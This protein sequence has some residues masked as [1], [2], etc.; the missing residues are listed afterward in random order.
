MKQKEPLVSIIA[1][2]Y[3]AESYLTRCI[4]SILRQ[5]YKNF[6]LLLIDDGSTDQSGKMCDDYAKRDI[7]IRVYHRENSGVSA[8]RNFALGLCQGSYIQFLDSDDWITTDSTKLLVRSALETKCDLVIADFYRVVGERVSQKGDIEED[9]IL[10]REQFAEH[11]M[12]N[13]AD[14]YYGV[15]WNKLYRRD[16]I[17]ENQ[18][19]MDPAISWC[20]DFLFNLEYIRHADTF[21]ALQAPVY[22]YF[23]RKGSLVSQS[24]SISN[25]IK[26]KLNI[27]DYYNQ[28]YKEIYKEEDYENIRLHIYHF[29]FASAKDNMLPPSPLPGAKK[30]G[31]ERK[32]ILPAAI[33]AEGILP[34]VYRIRKLLERLCETVAAKN[35]LTLDE[36]MLLLY[37]NQPACTNSIRSLAE[38]SGYSRRRISS[39]LQRLS[40]KELIKVTT[41]KRK[42]TCIQTLPAAKAILSD[43]E[44]AQNDFDIIRFRSL[45]EQ[46][47]IAYGKISHQIKENIEEALL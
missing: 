38:F 35:N 10:T 43:L 19:R 11:M 3:N 39:L 29:L 6:E 21:Y 40:K 13:P 23:K 26:T 22:Y 44:T 46:D 36:V 4:D 47:L 31:K 12:E 5:E 9:V 14:F 30:L 8:S 7:R 45:N 32:A 33:Q 17:E 34:E 37:I 28:F 27:F 24:F 1:P 15:L 18:I 20:E 16:I 42:D 25:T 2:V 41:S